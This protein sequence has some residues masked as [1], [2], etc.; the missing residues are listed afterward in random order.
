M[1]VYTHISRTELEDF[2]K[3]YDLGTLVSFAGIPQGVSNTNYKIVTDQG[4][5]ILTLF[6]SRVKDS[7]LPFFFDFMAHLN[8]KDISCPYALPDTAGQYFNKIAGR[9]A[10]IINFLPGRSL[11]RADLTS[12]HCAELGAFVARMHL[13]AADFDKTRVNGVS[14]PT[15]EDLAAKTKDKADTIYSGLARIV[16][17]EIEYLAAH[18]PAETDLP[19]AAVH[20][21]IFPDNVFF[22]DAQ[23]ISGI[24]DFYFSCTD[25]LLYDLALVI[26]AWCFDGN[27]EFAADKYQS[28]MQ[29]Y[30]ALRPLT[31]AETDRISFM[32]RAAALR[33][34]MTRSFAYLNRNPDDLVFSLDPLE[35]IAKLR[36]HQSADHD[37]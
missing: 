25:F 9:T 3:A 29:A 7:D 16:A 15:W 8:D 27:H 36:F 10:V 32:G 19:R 23:T 24:I 20:A 6:E 11:E 35:Y 4:P 37:R 17:D 2:L 12:H 30:T 22:D 5:Y 28:F 13:A 1:A 21:D 18:W 34:L 31:V 14:L 33:I 26:N